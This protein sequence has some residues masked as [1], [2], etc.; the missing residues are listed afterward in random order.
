MV[1]EVG[2]Y[3]PVSKTFPEKVAVHVEFLDAPVAVFTVL[4]MNVFFTQARQTHF[5][6][7]SKILGVVGVH[8][9]T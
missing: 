8:F 7:L 9:L 2:S 4:N 6:E 1:N 5:I 3:V